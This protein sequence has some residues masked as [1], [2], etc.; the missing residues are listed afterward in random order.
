MNLLMTSAESRKCFDIYNILKPKIDTLY[1]SSSLGLFKRGLLSIVYF[2]RVYSTEQIFQLIKAKTID[3]KIFPIDE[4]DIELIYTSN[5]EE[6]SMLPETDA[7]YQLADK[8]LLFEHAKKHN[9]SCPTTLKFKESEATSIMGEVVVKPARG[10]GSAGVKFFDCHRD[11]SKYLASLPN[12]SNMLI[13]ELISNKENV[14]AGCFLFDKGNLVSFYGHER[15]RTYP[16]S[17]GVTVCSKSHSYKRIMVLGERLL[18]PLGWSGLAMIEFMWSDKYNDFQLIEVNP[19]AWGSIML[20]EKCD[21]GLLMNYVDL[22][23]KKPVKKSMGRKDCSIRWLVP[24]DILNLVK[25]DVPLSD[26]I[27]ISRNNDCLINI[28]YSNLLQ[29]LL[30]HGFQFTQFTKIHKKFFTR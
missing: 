9:I 27:S 11:A 15:L 25:G 7:F 5:L 26:Y 30:F 21:S 13:Q 3:L 22:I 17:W 14:V 8:G 16:K 6:A 24:Y 20:S 2:K 1:L 4:V 19:R 18:G 29:S 10:T 28:S 23:F 12:R